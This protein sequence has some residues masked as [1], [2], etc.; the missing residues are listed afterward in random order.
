M[1]TAGGVAVGLREIAEVAARVSVLATESATAP[2]ARQDVDRIEAVLA[3]EGTASEALVALRAL[4]HGLPSLDA[5]VDR[6]ARRR[7]A[8]PLRICASRAV[9]GAP[10]SNTMTV[11]SSARC[12][13][14]ATTC[15]RSPPAAATTR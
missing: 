8:S 2:L 9:S 10:R 14:D 1:I 7:A 12:R 13:S 15:R 11:S 4:A 3:V 5:A 6:Y